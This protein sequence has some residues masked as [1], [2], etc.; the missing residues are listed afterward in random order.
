[1]RRFHFSFREDPYFD[2]RVNSPQNTP[3]LIV[4]PPVY[5]INRA[6]GRTDYIHVAEGAIEFKT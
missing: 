1:M 4:W 6:Y 2:Q 5:C 3:C